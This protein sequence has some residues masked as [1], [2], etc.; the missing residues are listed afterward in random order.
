MKDKK[1]RRQYRKL[2]VRKKLRDQRSGRP[3]LSVHRSLHYIY[4]QV[5]DDAHGRTL[6]FA[7]SLSKELR[8]QLPSGKNLAAAKAVGE[9][10]A[11][12]AL[13]AGVRQVAF[14][15]GG[16]LYRGRLKSLADAA[17]AAGLEF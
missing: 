1:V 15:R 13:A 7:S 17:R 11:R 16:N 8:D 2:R 9:L 4:A 3:R 5:I 14:D 10:I 6:A 12:K